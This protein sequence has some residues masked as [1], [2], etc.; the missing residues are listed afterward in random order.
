MLSNEKAA[1]AVCGE[2][3]IQPVRGRPRVFCRGACRQRA[4]ELRRWATQSAA[5]YA[6]NWRATGDEATADRIL[7]EAALIEVG[8]YR[9]ALA[10]R[11][12]DF[13]RRREEFAAIMRGER[14]RR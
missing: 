3:L 5:G 10:L 6:A 7:E 12:A 8:K 1:C 14:R 4:A 13:D 11:R 2:P 9:A